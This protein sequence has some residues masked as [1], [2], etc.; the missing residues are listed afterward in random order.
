MRL[1]L[2]IRVFVLLLFIHNVT[3]FGQ[4][5]ARA[6]K[7]EILANEN[8]D[9]TDRR[10]EIAVNDLG[11]LFTQ[12]PSQFVYGFIGKDMQRFRIKFISVIKNHKDPLE[13]FVYGKSMVKDN[14]CDFQGTIRITH[15]LD[16]KET[17][18]PGIRQGI[19]TGDYIFYENPRQKH[20]GIFGGSFVSNWMIDQGKVVYDDLAQ[21]ADG[22]S[23]NQ[24]VG[25][26]TSYSG[27]PDSPCHW[28]DYRIPLSG[29]LDDGAGEFHPNEKFHD[30]GWR[31]Y[32]DAYS[33]N[34]PRREQA[35]MEE[36]REWWK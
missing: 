9:Q 4:E 30:K 1:I 22:F 25:T 27:K 14:V 33:G 11:L 13:Y 8:L 26:W 29:E 24:F 3:G 15:I 23:N 21:V 35:L 5:L 16:W 19:I 28:G 31:N 6:F 10:K 12:T 2:R 7:S 18:A 17:D 20:V 34:S 32:H 36:Q